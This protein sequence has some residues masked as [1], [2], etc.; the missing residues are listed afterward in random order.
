M[1]SR[2]A[3]AAIVMLAALC[4]A[5]A[6]EA[7]P[8][9]NTDSTR[10]GAIETAYVAEFLHDEPTIA[11]QLGYHD[12]DER[13]PDLSAAG[14]A[15]RID[16]AKRYLAEL[17]ALEGAGLSS[18]DAGDV[19]ILNATLGRELLADAALERW[20]HEPAAY[21]RAAAYAV[22]GLFA[23]GFAPIDVRLRRAI[24]R[25]AA[26]PAMLATAAANITTVNAATAA[27]A[28]H[29]MSDAI[30]FFK[31][32]VPAAFASVNDVDEQDRFK[33][34]NGA[35]VDALTKFA[36]AMTAGPLAHPSGTFAIGRDAF[37]EE[38]ALQEGRPIALRDYERAGA[39]ALERTRA[40][41]IATAD[42]IDPGKPPAETY[43]ALG[44]NHP[45]AESLVPETEREIADLRSFVTDRHLVTLPS[46]DTILV[47]ETPDYD[48]QTVFTS[49]ST[50]GALEKV[51]TQAYYFV[52]PVDPAWTPAEK[53]QHL[54]FFNYAA[55]PVMLA[56][57]VMPGS[58]VEFAQRAG[59]RRSLVRAIFRS[60]SFAAG[61]AHYCEE[62]VVATG[63]SNGDPHV[64]L[65]SLGLALEREARYLVGLREHTQGMSIE[66]ATQFLIENAYLPSARA[67]DE[68]LRAA[69]EPLD[70]SY[71]LGELELLKL[72]DDYKKKMGAA[73]SL[74]AFNDASLA[75]G[76]PPIGVLRAL[77]LGQDD[78]GRL[79]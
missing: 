47:R 1:K 68:A 16:R 2:R 46:D 15:A 41:F 33:S 21:T 72:R 12:G 14:Y 32:D 43:A 35:V 9:A 54:E 27:T 71:T 74:Q 66:R 70:G 69:S 34:V 11:T 20:R 64:K 18:E 79:L 40:D 48:R 39:V 49:M 28:P 65:A 62:M 36:A 78:D 19:T 57:D 60:P 73:Y 24:A 25:E 58:S 26:I 29:D 50:P 67:R 75:H 37:A 56:Q 53:E 22:G 17:G 55:F 10:L 51:S 30:D 23:R 76:N 59:G 8:P 31:H 7:L 44:R 45:D 63:L 6:Q 42:R 5:D 4:R 77:L 61:W 13:L 3:I 52:T 38:I